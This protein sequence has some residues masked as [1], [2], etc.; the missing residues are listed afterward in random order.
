MK[1]EIIFGF[2]FLLTVA[3][4]NS[5]ARF[6]FDLE[7]Y[8]VDDDSYSHS[9]SKK[10]QEEPLHKGKYETKMIYSFFFICI[11]FIFIQPVSG[12]YAPV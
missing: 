2:F 8:L 7:N 11:R 3:I 12:K 4:T 9:L 1:T 6:H 10:N 5:M